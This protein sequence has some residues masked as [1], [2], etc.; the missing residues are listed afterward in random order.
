ME[1][2]K[3][4]I[5]GTGDIAKSKHLPGYSKLSDEIEMYAACDNV[6]WKLKASADAYNILHRF[7]DY[8][9]LLAMRE[10][11]IVSIC[12]PNYMHAPVTGREHYSVFCTKTLPSFSKSS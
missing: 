11:D 9:K 6:P 2:L 4:G 3:Y 10:I 7:E 12:L 8:K 5:I 1:K